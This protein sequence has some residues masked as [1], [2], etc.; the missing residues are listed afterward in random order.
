MEYQEQAVESSAAEHI[1]PVLSPV[2]ITID[3]DDLAFNSDE[4][5][6]PNNVEN[7]QVSTKTEKSSG[8]E[9]FCCVMSMHDG[10][11]L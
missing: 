6:V 10:V 11:V 1:T 4:A 9:G 5:E 8:D 3:E 7:I 2:R